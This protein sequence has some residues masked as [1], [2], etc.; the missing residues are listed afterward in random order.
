MD[1]G[2]TQK[3]YTIEPVESPIPRKQP[4]P[5]REPAP[6]PVPEKVPA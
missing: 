6:L 4:E 1:I 2:E 5:V 3:T